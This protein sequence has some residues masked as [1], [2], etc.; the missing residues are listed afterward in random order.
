MANLSYFIFITG[1]I[2]PMTTI[3]FIQSSSSAMKPAMLTQFIEEHSNNHCS[4]KIIQ[5]TAA[6]KDVTMVN[7]KNNKFLDYIYSLNIKT[8]TRTFL[9]KGLKQHNEAYVVHCDNL[10]ECEY[11]FDD[12][13]KD[14]YWN[15]NSIFFVTVKHFS[16]RQEDFFRKLHYLYVFKTVLVIH[17]YIY[18]YD[19]RLGEHCNFTVSAIREYKCDSLSSD[20]LPSPIWA[21]IKASLEERHK[22]P[23]SECNISVI[24]SVS[25]PLVFMP[26]DTHDQPF[27]YEEEF[28]RILKRM[29]FTNIFISYNTNLTRNGLVC[30]NHTVSGILGLLQQGAIDYLLGGP[31]LSHYR[32]QVFDFTYPHFFDD[33]VLIVPKARQI[34]K[35]EVLYKVFKPLVWG[36]ISLVFV[37]VTL[38]AYLLQFSWNRDLYHLVLTTLDMFSY[39]INNPPKKKI[40][41]FVLSWA[42]FAWLIMS[43]YQSDLTSIFTRPMYY[44]QVNSLPEILSHNY[45]LYLSRANYNYMKGSA[46]LDM[47][48]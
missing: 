12:L 25:V 29:N 45:K 17:D 26:L 14:V 30:E 16:Y 38:V 15:P 36:L 21:D 24:V 27:G 47:G 48:G 23:Y 9:S 19:F 41:C 33:F 8:Q 7:V 18:F 11:G 32:L 34:D 35:W 1:I 28:I 10:E 31:I 46:E 42:L 43:F 37:C 5:N 3:C 44:N 39:L 20:N 22:T 2:L 40:T 4:L 6:L 13:V